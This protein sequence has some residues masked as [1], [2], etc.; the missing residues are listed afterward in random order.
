MYT[1]HALD[2]I[3]PLPLSFRRPPADLAIDPLYALLS[4]PAAEADVQPKP[5]PAEDAE[6]GWIDYAPGDPLPPLGVEIAILLSN[7]ATVRKVLKGHGEG[8]LYHGF[9]LAYRLVGGARA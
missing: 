9:V 3:D 1:H 4:K 6:E 2:R 7:G 5:A 8:W